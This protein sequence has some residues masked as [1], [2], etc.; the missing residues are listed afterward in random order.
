MTGN[1]LD[2]SSDEEEEEKK[3]ADGDGD[4]DGSNDSVGEI[5][6]VLDTKSHLLESQSNL[7]QSMKSNTEIVRIMDGNESMAS[8]SDSHH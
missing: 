6:K 3:A 4:G 2:G 8:L 5:V 1:M 7:T